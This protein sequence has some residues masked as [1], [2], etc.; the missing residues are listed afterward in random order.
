MLVFKEILSVYTEDKGVCGF[1]LNLVYPLSY[2]K[3][4]KVVYARIARKRVIL[5]RYGVL[6]VGFCTG[7]GG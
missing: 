5:S 7:R 4:R 3:P 6:A 2:Y 1:V